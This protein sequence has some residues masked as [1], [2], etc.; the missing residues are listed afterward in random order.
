MAWLPKGMS[1]AQ[2]AEQLGISRHKLG[3]VLKG[4]AGISPD[5]ALRLSAWLETSP[6]VWLD[7]QSAWDLAQAQRRGIPV[8]IPLQRRSAPG[9]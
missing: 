4:D 9:K 6:E 1:T 5:I 2:A 7:M 8:I 3:R